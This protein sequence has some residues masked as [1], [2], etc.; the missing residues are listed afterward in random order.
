MDNER[1]TVYCPKCG[2]EMNNN[3]RFCMKCGFLNYNHEANQSIQK[4]IKNEDTSYELGS[5]KLIFDQ[6][7]DSRRSLA[8]STGNKL[9]CYLI[10]FFLFLGCLVVG[11]LL[12]VKGDYQFQAIVHSAFPVI[13]IIISLT[14]LYVFAFQLIYMKCNRPWWSALIPV[15]NMMVLADVLFQKKWIGLLTLI[16]I[17]GQIVMMVMLYKLGESFNNNGVLTVIFAP[18]FIPLMGYNVYGYKGYIFVNENSKFNVE[19]EYAFKK[20]FLTLMILPLLV[21]VGAISFT[22]FSIIEET[23]KRL[24]NSS[25]V[26][27][28]NKLVAEV[29]IKVEADNIICNG[30]NYNPNE[31]VYYFY[32]DDVGKVVFIPF[33]LT[34]NTIQ[35]Y[36]KVDNTG[37]KTKYYV[38]LSDGEKG[39]PE[40]ESKK[41]TLDSIVEYKKINSIPGAVSCNFIE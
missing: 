11:F 30:A 14:F 28:S 40:T 18:I 21:G 38:S 25:Y 3:M 24:G 2:A 10:N 4:Y 7:D 33:Y 8:T 6:T 27:T 31:G 9:F 20:V 36:V 35:G 13:M 32:F 37:D 41:I 19:R 22:N 5:G 12:S 1:Y 39:F 26:T 34:R 23:V 29:K 15:Y 17:V 16:P